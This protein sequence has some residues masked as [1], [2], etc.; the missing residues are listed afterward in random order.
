MPAEKPRLERLDALRGM[1]M[2]FVVF[3]HTLYDAVLLLGAPWWLFQNP[4]IFPIQMVF[5][6]TFVVA[7]GVSSRLSRSNA[8]RGGRLLA[9]AMGLTVITT[10]MDMPITF[11]I[12]HML[13]TCMLLYALLH[14]WTDALPFWVFPALALVS[15]LWVK[16]TTLRAPLLW[17]L[18]VPW[19][20]LESWDYYPLFPWVFLFFAGT[21]LGTPLLQWQFVGRKPSFFS[22]LGR[23]SLL[24]YLVHQP[25]LFGVFWAL[26]FLFFQG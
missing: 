22:R 17:F 6:S 5:V 23:H 25:V 2:C 1:A 16:T 19:P 7:S 10:L 12:L 15:L 9:V 26:R 13:A 18:G 20:G 14:R 24:I 4:V 11:G 21:K 8:R 3:H